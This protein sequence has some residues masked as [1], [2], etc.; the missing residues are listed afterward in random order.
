MDT[1][2]DKIAVCV[3]GGGYRAML[4]HLGTFWYLS[5][6]GILPEVDRI[7]SVSG[8]SITCGLLGLRWNEVGFGKPGHPQRF[9]SLVVAPIRR[10]ASTTIDV[11]SVLRG[12]FLPGTISDRIAKN[13]DDV[14]F[15]KATLQDLPDAP[16]FVLNA[17]N[18]Q[19]GVLFRFAKP[20]IADYRIGQVKNPRRPLSEAVTASSAFP[21]VLSPAR[22]SFRHEEWERT[23]GADLHEP[24]YTTKIL[25][26][27]GGVYDNMGLQPA[28]SYRTILVSDAGGRMQPEPT[29]HSNP[30][31]HGLRC[32]GLIDNQVRS[33]R[34]SH[35]VE[36]FKTKRREG[37]YWGLWT[38]PDDYPC[39]SRL[40][41]PKERASD[42][43][44]T[45][46]RLAKMDAERQERLINFGYAM[47]ER[48]VRGRWR[49]GALAATAFPYTRGI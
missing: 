42:L 3:S 14:L 34:R 4:F 12:M 49:E 46:T 18:V 26:T 6:A 41:I 27:D 11:E 47:A 32:N 33:L 40:E 1:L 17:T 28:N 25:L 29:P 24:P 44:H 19:T 36:D 13:Y 30:V 7:S 38:D 35:L 21:P 8:G 45:P 39:T 23:E 5:D 48:A 2:Q 15:G 37:A 31:Q 20:Y 9:Q 22:L 10:M 43:A 16:R